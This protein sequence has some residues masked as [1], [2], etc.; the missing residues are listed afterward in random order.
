M[1]QIS[2]R[3]AARRLGVQRRAV[4]KRI[5]AGTL[6]KLPNGKLDWLQVE[7]QW[8]GNRD[9]S[10]VRKTEAPHFTIPPAATGR[11]FADAKTKREYVRLEKEALQLKRA[12]GEV[13]SV[14]EINAFVSG[15]I[16]RARDTFLRIGPELQ[17]RLAYETDPH[18]CERLIMDQVTRGLNQM[19]EYKPEP[20]I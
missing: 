13:V 17:D 16:I 5:E 11:N 14:A 20:Q 18:E 12:K 9:E 3:E 10:K 1:E 19:A 4:Q 7:R 15:M 2:I 8:T 6:S